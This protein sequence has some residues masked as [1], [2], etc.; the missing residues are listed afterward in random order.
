MSYCTNANVRAICDTDVTN[1]EIDILILECDDLLDLM[2]NMGAVTAN[3]RRALSSTY[4]AIRCMLK[5][6]SAEAMGEW[7]GDRTYSL[8][9]LNE[10]FDR[11]QKAVDGG[12]SFRYD[13]ADMRRTP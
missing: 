7:R 3:V 10:E 11:M 12:Y 9:K 8:K 1:A 5:D 4:V 13:Y 6:P 2:L